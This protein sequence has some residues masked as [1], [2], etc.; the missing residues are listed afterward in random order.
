[1]I[2][3][4]TVEQKRIIF[5][6]RNI[7]KVMNKY[8]TF[9][10]FALAYSCFFVTTQILVG[11]PTGGYNL[12]D[13]EFND[14]TLTWGTDNC[15]KHGVGDC[16]ESMFYMA[17]NVTEQG[18]NLRI[19][20]KN[21]TITCNGVT[22][23]YSS[24]QAV[25]PFSLAYGYFEIR[26]K[27]PN[28][29]GL[30]PAFWFWS[31]C[32]SNAYSEIDVFE[33]CGC[34]CREFLA[35]SWYETDYDGINEGIEWATH[36]VQEIDIDGSNACEN[37]HTYGLE[38]TNDILGF[39]VDDSLKHTIPN[40]RNHNP[41]PVILNLAVE[42]CTAGC[43]VSHYCGN[44]TWQHNQG[45]RLYCNSKTFLE[46]SEVY[47]IDYVKVWKKQNEAIQL[48]APEELC[49]GDV[50]TAF[51][52]HVPGATYSWSGSP[53]LNITTIP[54]QDWNCVPPGVKEQV[55]IT[56][57]TSGLKTLTVT[58]TFPGGYIES[59]SKNI[60]VYAAPPPSPTGITFL[61]NEEDCCY[62]ANAIGGNGATYYVWKIGASSNE[63]T[64]EN[65]TF[66]YCFLPDRVAK[67]SVKAGNACGESSFFS[68][69][70]TLPDPIVPGCGKHMMISPNPTTGFITVEIV[71]PYVSLFTPGIIQITDIYGNIKVEK[72]LEINFDVIDVT[73]LNNGLYRI[74]F[75]DGKIVLST[76]FI[77]E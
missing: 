2:I 74:S 48:Y 17:A 50:A 10:K 1:M 8:L 19:E 59:K 11:Q 14:G 38:W 57:V 44:L 60:F 40:H 3:Q 56:A 45:C 12:Y 36:K 69:S 32:G 31:G 24:G 39:Y 20:A 15:V 43:N 53:G 49:V 34:N 5:G 52:T 18:G 66:D 29:D 65:P 51:A 25:S 75:I 9:L 72:A 54:W 33:F 28:G 21:E 26:A 62:Y 46:G 61:F 7:L 77:K 30:W 41:M 13:E 47:E 37:F 71:S 6:T 64:T 73:T 27:I 67:V 63:Y 35:G 55:N 42:G 76:L 70:T 16:E 23:N 68:V 22:K 58:V 4:D